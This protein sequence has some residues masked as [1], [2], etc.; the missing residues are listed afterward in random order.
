M[1]IYELLDHFI[2]NKK[3]YLVSYLIIFL[4]SLPLL[5]YLQSVENNKEKYFTAKYTLNMNA[6]LESYLEDVYKL[7]NEIETNFYYYDRYLFFSD[8]EVNFSLDDLYGEKTINNSGE[9]IRALTLDVNDAKKKDLIRIFL[10]SVNSNTIF[11]NAIN[12][13]YRNELIEKYETN[14]DLDK[15]IQQL[16]TRSNFTSSN[17]DFDSVYDSMYQNATEHGFVSLEMTLFDFMFNKKDKL[18]TSL[19]ESSYSNVKS[20]LILNLT[21]DFDDLVLKQEAKIDYQ[22]NLFTDIKGDYISDLQS[23]RSDLLQKF[24]ISEELGIIN[25][26]NQIENTSSERGKINSPPENIIFFGTKYIDNE[27][28]NIQKSID[29]ANTLYINL[30]KSEYNRVNSSLLDTTNSRLS[31]MMALQTIYK[32]NKDY[33]SIVK[34][35]FEKE[36][37][38]IRSTNIDF[39]SIDNLSLELHQ[40]KSVYF[41][42]MN[43]IAFQIFCF[44]II[45]FYFL[46]YSGYKKFTNKD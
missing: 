24:K 29:V 31:N 44:M 12:K 2:K 20:E 17:P 28:K 30:E 23:I 11:R 15:S 27:I 5:Y 4:F 18:L 38:N 39:F 46:T 33:L 32:R 43:I 10:K 40:G 34:E 19:L 9:K 7:I 14:L 13:V 35:E 22:K 25:P 45:F 16:L 1:S 37:N 3:K 6:N 8:K 41:F 36:I 21:N 42:I 26:V